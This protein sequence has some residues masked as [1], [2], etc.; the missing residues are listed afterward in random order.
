MVGLDWAPIYRMT[1]L[2]SVLEAPAL[3]AGFDDFA[4]MGQAVEE[5]GCHLGI[6][7]DGGPLG[8]GKIGRHDDGG[9]LVELADHIEQ[10]LAAGLGEGEIAEFIEYDEVFSDEIFRD[11]S[12]P[13]GARFG[14]EP[15]DEIDSVVKA[16]TF[17][18]ANAIASN[19]DG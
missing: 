13:S 5:R 12:L 17:A 6:G 19:G 10:Q 16:A 2:F 1:Q 9:A 4:V 18:G 11:P 7:E 15:V 14:L 3:V 8:K